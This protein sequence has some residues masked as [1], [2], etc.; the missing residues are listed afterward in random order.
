MQVCTVMN[1][2]FH[3]Y[4]HLLLGMYVVHSSLRLSLISLPP[5]TTSS[6]VALVPSVLL[7]AGCSGWGNQKHSIMVC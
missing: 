1:S 5:I 3:M 2:M 4:V 6:C 7:W